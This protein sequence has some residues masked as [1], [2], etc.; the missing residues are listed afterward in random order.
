[1]ANNDL[2]GYEGIHRRSQQRVLRKRRKRRGD[3]R[4]EGE[5]ITRGLHLYKESCNET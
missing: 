4:I 5:H 2:Q 3:Q 1:M